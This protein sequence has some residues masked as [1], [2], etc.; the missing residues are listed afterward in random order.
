MLKSVLNIN[1]KNWC[2]GWSSNTLATWCKEL[3][4]W[5]RPWCW[6]RLKAGGKGDDGGWNGWMASL[7]QWSWVW[8]GSGSWWWTRK[9][10][11]LQSWGRAQLSNWTTVNYSACCAGHTHLRTSGLGASEASTSPMLYTQSYPQ[12]PGPWAQRRACLFWI[13]MKT[14]CVLRAVML[15]AGAADWSL[16]SVLSFLSVRSITKIQIHLEL[17]FPASL[18]V[19]CHVTSF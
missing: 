13:R 11:M 6:E 9:P 18:A 3:T 14:L 19:D 12:A 4:H 10:G 8:E 16:I 17:H 1:W 7:T 15:V 2:W 5:K